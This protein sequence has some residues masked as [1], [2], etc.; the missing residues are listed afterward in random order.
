MIKLT[1]RKND[2]VNTTSN[3]N[4]IVKISKDD[5]IWVDVLNLSEQEKLQ[6]FET[7]NVR[8]QIPKKKKIRHSFRFIEKENEILINTGLLKNET[9]NLTSKPVTFILKDNFLISYHNILHLS[10]D[11]IYA[12]IKNENCSKLYGR[13][14]FLKI[15]EKI[16]E[17]DID[18]IE[19]I[20]SDIVELS[21]QIT[22]KE[23]LDEDLIYRITSLQEML[24][25]IRSNIIDKQR[26]ISSI[27]KTD[28]FSN[29]ELKKHITI[30]EKDISSILDYTS[31]DFERLEYLQDTLMGLINLRQNVIMKIFTIVSVI[32]LP[33]TL[34]ASIYGMNFANMPE[35]KVEY[36]YPIALLIMILVSLLALF[37][38]KHKKWI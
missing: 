32:F 14:I 24:I 18:I 8:F 2:K 28:N 36:A 9:N 10:F 22:V 15:F 27:Y 34:I 7:F 11:E 33:P 19:N 26:V 25:R 31:F 20:T 3:F 5:F 17:F 35:L 23:D 16:L 21:N 12:E 30:I 4:E 29:K 38:F 1:Y 6:L 13:L 37:I